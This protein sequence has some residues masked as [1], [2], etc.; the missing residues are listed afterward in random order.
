MP[1]EDPYKRLEEA[2]AEQGKTKAE[3]ARTIG[4][5]RSTVQEYFEKRSGAEKH[6]AKICDW[7]DVSMD[8]LVRGHP[9]EDRGIKSGAYRIIRERHYDESYRKDLRIAQLEE[10][11]RRLSGKEPPPPLEEERDPKRPAP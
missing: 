2:M 9:R 5:N 11:I 3:L 8:W 10:M 7:L 1:T 4:V 6:W